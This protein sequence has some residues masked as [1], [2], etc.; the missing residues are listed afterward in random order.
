MCGSFNA[1]DI[2]RK[3]DHGKA[4]TFKT[5]SIHCDELH[6]ALTFPF[7]LLCGSFK[8]AEHKRLKSLGKAHHMHI[9]RFYEDYELAHMTTSITWLVETVKEIGWLDFYFVHVKEVDM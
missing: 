8:A 2:K 4:H 6:Q 5:A 7:E 3:Q 9:L 1:A